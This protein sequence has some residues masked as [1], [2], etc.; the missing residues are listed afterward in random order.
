MHAQHDGGD[1]VILVGR[2]VATTV[3]DRPPLVMHA[4]R[5]RGLPTETRS[6]G[7]LRGKDPARRHGS[8]AR[9]LL[10][11]LL[12]RDG[13]DEDRGSLEGDLGRQPAPRQARRRGRDRLHAP[14]RAL[15]RL[16]RRDELPRGRARPG[17][18]RRGPAR[19]DR[20]DLR[21]RD[22][23]HGVQPP[24]RHREGDGDRR[25]DRQGPGRPE[26][27]RRLEQAGVRRDGRR[28]AARP[29]RPLRLRAGVVGD[30]R[31]ACGRSRA[32]TTSTAASGS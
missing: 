8:Q 18:A 6:E 30:R 2:V 1:H 20:A 26:H 5:M 12:V 28:P 13:R 11:Q 23:P 24:A 15:D 14:D 10:G 19:R 9:P 7:E 22:D 3:T 27:R 31:S 25:P 4:G 17:R 29:R 16:R 21:L 32:A